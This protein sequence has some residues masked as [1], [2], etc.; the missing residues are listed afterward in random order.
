MLPIA[1]QILEYPSILCP[2]STRLKPAILITLSFGEA[3]LCGIKHQAL[4]TMGCHSMYKDFINFQN[5]NKIHVNNS[6]NVGVNAHSIVLQASQVWEENV[7]GNRIHFPFDSTD[8][9]QKILE[10]CSSLYF[11][12]RPH[13]TPLQP[14]H[15]VEH[16]RHGRRI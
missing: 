1:S 6:L 4:K 16:S 12:S 14:A 15:C 11:Q 8:M 3:G 10:Y 5:Y 7:W 13:S 9:L 2:Y